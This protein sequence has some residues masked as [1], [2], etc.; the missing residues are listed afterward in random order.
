VAR[1]PLRKTDVETMEAL[2]RGIRGGVPI[3]D[4]VIE[5]LLKLGM[6]EERKRGAWSLT[7][8]AKTYLL[9]RKSVLR[10]KRKK[11]MSKPGPLSSS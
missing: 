10:G 5:R 7:V 2:E 6:I 8:R 3:E 9:R 1:Q 4:D 11:T